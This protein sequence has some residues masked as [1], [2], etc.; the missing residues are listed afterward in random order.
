MIRRPAV[1]GSFYPGSQIALQREL[2]TLIPKMD[3]KRSV[4]GLISPHAGYIYSGA[5]AGKGFANIIIP[6]RVVILGVNHRGVGKDFAVDANH[7]WNTPLGDIPIDRELAELITGG[8]HIFAFDSVASA[9]E[10]SLEVQVPFIQYLNPNARILPITISS[11]NIESLMEGGRELGRKLAGIPDVLIVASTDMSHYIDARSASIQ[12]HKAIDR[13]LALDPQGLH[14]TVVKER[15]SMC[16]AAPT[17]MM[18]TAAL[19]LGAQHSEIIH[20]TH[21]GEVGGDF[22]RVVAY[23]SMIIY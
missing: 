16:G 10:H 3:F 21:S 15:I 14:K 1:A 9:M 20:Y 18:L 5:C 17:A 12:D 6:D 4:I 22:D 2:E 13:I 19:E 23:L 7:Y 8:S 11:M